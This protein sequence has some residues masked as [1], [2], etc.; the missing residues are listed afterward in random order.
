[1]PLAN[2][3]FG[4]Y[5]QVAKSICSSGAYKAWRGTI[6][7]DLT[8]VHRQQQEV[9]KKQNKT[10]VD[11]EELTRQLKELLQV[12]EYEVEQLYGQ[13]EAKDGDQAMVPYSPGSAPSGLDQV[14]H[15]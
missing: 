7:E 15:Y 8:D 6:K 4:D 10:I 14:G 5:K 12:K 13:L 2:V 9:I 3:A 1:M 11:L